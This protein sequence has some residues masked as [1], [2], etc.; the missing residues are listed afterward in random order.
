VQRELEGW[1]DLFAAKVD[2][3]L[4]EILTLTNTNRF[5]VESYEVSLVA[6][7]NGAHFVKH[8]DMPIGPGRRPLGGDES[9]KQDRLLSA[10]YYFHAEPRGFTGGD[11]RLH[12][13]GSEDA[14]GDYV[15]VEPA[16]NRLVVFPSW[17]L[18]EVRPVSVPTGRF[19]DQ[20]F[21]VNCWLC[22]R[23]GAS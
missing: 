6:H 5:P 22:A 4:D 15:D 16:D 17:V 23:L 21:A 1:P 7:G 19:E 12:R 10:V 13:F 11:L 14:P 18:H 9:G 8:T 3:R 2:A 20:R